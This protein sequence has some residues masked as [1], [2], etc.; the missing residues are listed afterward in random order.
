LAPT[1]PGFLARTARAADLQRDGRVLVVIELNGGND[2]INTVVPF[3]VSENSS[4]GTDHGTA[5]PVFL[6]GRNVRGGLVGTT[7][8]L[9]D[10]DPNH[11]DLKVGIDFRQVYASLLEDWLG[12]PSKLALD[13]IFEQLPLFRKT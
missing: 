3:A 10:L 6:A 1:I 7:P 12:L 11:G 4:G 5:G 8:S 2:G 13:G 9:L